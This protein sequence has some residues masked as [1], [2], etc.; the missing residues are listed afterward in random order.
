M[1]C[2]GVGRVTMRRHPP[3]LRWSSQQGH[4]TCEGCA[5][6]GQITMQ[7]QPRGQP[8]ELPMGPRNVRGVRRSRA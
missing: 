5:E 3:G 8:V 6:M 2:A 4:G 1:E 7:T